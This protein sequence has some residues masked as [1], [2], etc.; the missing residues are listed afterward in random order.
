MRIIL[1]GPPGVGKGTQAQKLSGE[2]SVDQFSTGD[3]LRDAIKNNTSLGNKA[4]SYMVKGE[5]VPDDIMLGL[6]EK[7]LFGEDKPDGFILDGFPRTISQAEGLTKLFEKHKIE[8]NAVVLFESDTE[9]IADRLSARR[10][11]RDCNAV[12]NL[13]SN[14]PK[15]EGRCD[16][17]GGELFQRDDDRK[18]TVMK[19]LLVYKKQTEPLIDF[20]KSSGI[21]RKVKAVGSPEEVYKLTKSVIG[22]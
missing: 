8:L 14:P 2:F 18:E 10:T 11:C 17:C 19:R 3:I 21:L 9:I 15:E 22:G 16:K 1:L 7:V 5:L 6:I 4:S 13:I 20:Y 12:Y